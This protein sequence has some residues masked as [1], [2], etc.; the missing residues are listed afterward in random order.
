MRTMLYYHGKKKSKNITSMSASFKLTD[1]V[2][3]LVPF[4]SPSSPPLPHSHDSLNISCSVLTQITPMINVL[5]CLFCTLCNCWTF[6]LCPQF[7]GNSCYR[8]RSMIWMWCVFASKFTCKMR[9][10][11][12]TPC[13]LPSSP[14]PSMTTVSWHK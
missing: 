10:G 7:P 4:S 6:V 3:I 9:P 2:F 5:I 14:T 11:C 13:C 8:L 12:T 1:L